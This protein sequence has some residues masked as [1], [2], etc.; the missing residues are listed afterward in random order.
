MSRTYENSQTYS[1][2]TSMQTSNSGVMRTNSWQLL[3]SAVIIL[4]GAT[5]GSTNEITL[6]PRQDHWTVSITGPSSVATNE[7][8]QGGHYPL[9]VS[10]GGITEG[11]QQMPSLGGVVSPAIIRI[12]YELRSCE[13]GSS[14]PSIVQRFLKGSPVVPSAT[15]LPSKDNSPTPPTP[16]PSS[17]TSPSSTPSS[18][19][20][21]LPCIHDGDVNA[22][23]F[24]TSG[25]A[26][27]AYW[28]YLQLI[29]PTFEEYCAADCDGDSYVTNSD[30][31]TIFNVALG[32]DSCLDP[33][34]TPTFIPTP[35]P[36]YT[37][38]PTL[39]PTDTPTKTPT[40]TSTFSPTL[41]PSWTLTNSPTFSPTLSP[42]VEPTSTPN[43]F[44]T[45][46]YIYTPYISPTELP[47]FSPTATTTPIPT[48]DLCGFVSTSDPSPVPIQGVTVTLYRT[49]WHPIDTTTTDEYGTYC[50][51]GLMSN[52][53]YV[54]FDGR[55]VGHLMRYLGGA[56]ERVAAQVVVLAAPTTTT[57]V[58]CVIDPGGTLS[59]VVK[60]GQES[61]L[62]DIV[63]RVYYV[64]GGQP[65][66]EREKVTGT[67]G[68]YE[69]E[70]LE[71][72]DYFIL[73]LG[74][75]AG[76]EDIFYPAAKFMRDASAVSI[77]DHGSF[78]DIDFELTARPGIRGVIEN[79]M[80]TPV[81]GIRI[82]AMSG[83]NVRGL[84]ETNDEGDWE[85]RGLNPEDNPFLILCRGGEIGWANGT[86]GSGVN[87]SGTNVTD[88]GEFTIDPAGIITG[89]VTYPVA[90]PATVV[91]GCYF[92][93]AFETLVA[94]RQLY[95]RSRY[96]VEGL[97]AGAYYVRAVLDE[98]GD[99]ELSPGETFGIYG[100][101]GNPEA[102]VVVAGETT[103]GADIALP[104]PTPSITP[105]TTLTPDLTPPPS[106][107]ITP[108]PSV[109]A[110]NPV[111]I[112]GSAETGCRVAASGGAE[113]RW[114][115]AVDG[116]FVLPVLLVAG[117]TNHLSIMATDKAGNQSPARQISVTH[118]LTIP[119]PAKFFAV[120]E[121]DENG[122]ITVT[123]TAGSVT[124]G[125]MVRTTN[126]RT[127]EAGATTADAYGGFQF[128][129]DG[130]FDTI[131][132]DPLSV[133]VVNGAGFTGPRTTS[134][135]GTEYREENHPRLFVGKGSSIAKITVDYSALCGD[136]SLNV[137]TLGSVGFWYL[138]YENGEMTGLVSQNIEVL[139][140]QAC[141]GL[142]QMGM[143]PFNLTYKAPVGEL[144]PDRLK[145]N[146]DIPTDMSY[147][148]CDGTYYLFGESAI[149][150]GLQW[151][152][153]PLPAHE[154]NHSTS[155]R[156]EAMFGEYG[157]VYEHANEYSA[158][159]AIA[160]IC[161]E[162][163]TGGE[164][165]VN[166][167]S[168]LPLTVCIG[169]GIPE[170]SLWVDASVSFDGGIFAG[171]FAD[172]IV[173]DEY[174]S[175]ASAEFK[176]PSPEGFGTPNEVSIYG[177]GSYIVAARFQPMGFPE[178]LDLWTVPGR[179]QAIEFEFFEPCN[180]RKEIIYYYQKWVYDRY[181][182][183][184]PPEIHAE[185][186]PPNRIG[187]W[188]ISEDNTTGGIDIESLT[189]N[190]DR[191]VVTP[192]NG[193]GTFIIRLEDSENDA[194][195][196]EQKAMIIDTDA[197]MSSISEPLFLASI[198][199]IYGWGRVIDMLKLNTHVQKYANTQPDSIVDVTRHL[200]WQSLLTADCRY[201]ELVAVIWGNTHE[202]ASAFAYESGQ[203]IAQGGGSPRDTSMD[204]HNN[205]IGR[206][207]GS[208]YQYPVSTWHDE[209][210]QN[211][212][213]SAI[214]ELAANSVNPCENLNPEIPPYIARMY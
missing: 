175:V 101:L 85:I 66:I 96:T 64:G 160:W 17:P 120:S 11:L 34:P 90:D 208:T 148:A 4:V 32:M 51:S 63:I 178:A 179:V 211:C 10:S 107:V 69:V 76:Y 84:G 210:M 126:L 74:R 185:I 83:E 52:K 15:V 20:P 184:T 138:V 39:T 147:W 109:V 205:V 87:L 181:P 47:F 212:F 128:A 80:D 209:E 68:Y 135:T 117:Q 183:H 91:V 156:I 159:E 35:S 100:G 25:D 165:N 169:K 188:S 113:S 114:S 140:N 136:S 23:D 31:A 82:I 190:G 196:I 88:L 144:V 73:A 168:N 54:E 198:P 53:Y 213:K 65:K 174:S 57:G 149:F 70:G 207:L 142:L 130:A 161:Q 29:I 104:T 134:A 163:S 89:E 59:G 37:D 170:L 7:S 55:Q 166:C 173:F 187:Y 197:L 67:D 40:V 154:I 103:T 204:L 153:E 177:G 13:G 112:R 44:A 18:P 49:S 72:G 24:V 157:M 86:L 9:T 131:T 195:A 22:D 115:H 75:R 92:D 5:H 180:Y 155:N 43:F 108:V 167:E 202:T 176:N 125:A 171:K 16:T 30:A 38:T 60:G 132:N 193:P 119:S 186:L 97:P 151:S 95:G 71:D 141:S 122:D 19:T 137:R 28:I 145:L 194:C 27:L 189:P 46:T 50:F 206:Q 106:P 111:I 152:P 214:L 110:V 146:L 58:D 42:T 191:A 62:Q 36:T 150:D 1:G 105:N 56:T 93:I 162:L 77:V 164:K 81:P 139:T 133:E 116:A 41:T 124:A 172:W 203:G 94:R 48:A 201:G 182:F 158:K 21:G 6:V 2:G 12:S 8:S 200:Y 61:P 199:L 192:G 102:V 121:P 3:V 123:G 78:L 127:G 129:S 79:A 45:I 26:Q 33:L 98:D 99:E 14:Q 143:L 118:A